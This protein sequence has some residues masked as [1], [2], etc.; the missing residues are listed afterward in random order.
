MPEKLCPTP[1]PKVERNGFRIYGET[2]KMVTIDDYFFY[3][4]VR[5][6]LLRNGLHNLF[7]QGW[8]NTWNGPERITPGWIGLRQGSALSC[9]LGMRFGIVSKNHSDGDLSFIVT[10]A[11]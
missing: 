1:V 8:E 3:Y 4:D 5:K 6:D 9:H 2:P 10:P 11:W 7:S